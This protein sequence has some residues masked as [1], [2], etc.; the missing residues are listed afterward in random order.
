[1]RSP[2]RDAV[3][4]VIAF[5]GWGA[6]GLQYVLSIGTALAA[7]QRLRPDTKEPIGPPS[8]VKHFHDSRLSMTNT[9]VQALDVGIARDR[10]FINLGELTGNIWTT[11]LR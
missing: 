8:A 11:S 7:A 3:A 10:I 2:I 4:A 6:L 1:V 5:V 9:G